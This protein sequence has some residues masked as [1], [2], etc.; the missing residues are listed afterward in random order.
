AGLYLDAAGVVQ[1]RRDPAREQAGRLEQQTGVVKGRPGEGKDT[2]VVL[3]IEG[4]PGLVVEDGAVLH[5]QRSWQTADQ[6]GL[7]GVVERAAVQ[8]P[9]RPVEDRPGRHGKRGRSAGE[10]AVVPVK[11]AGDG[12]GV[13]ALQAAEAEVQVRDTDRAAAV[14]VNR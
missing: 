12:N 9:T 11:G 14:E 8:Y 5:R 6:G 3:A 10:G 7:A 2:A 1:R 13:A 4:G